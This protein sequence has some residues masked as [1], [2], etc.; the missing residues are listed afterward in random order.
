[1]QEINIIVTVKSLEEL[2]FQ[3]APIPKTSL[4][5]IKTFRSGKVLAA[6]NVK[7]ESCYKNL[8]VNFFWTH[9]PLM[10]EESPSVVKQEVLVTDEG[11]KIEEVVYEDQMNVEFIEEPDYFEEETIVSSQEIKNEE[12]VETSQDPEIMVE[13][14][15]QQMLRFRNVEGLYVPDSDLV[16]ELEM[17]GVCDFCGFTRKTLGFKPFLKHCATHLIKKMVGE[18][19]NCRACGQTFPSFDSVK[20]HA[21]CCI[22]RDSYRDQ[23]DEIGSE[24]ELFKSEKSKKLIKTPRNI[25]GKGIRPYICNECEKSFAGMVALQNH[26]ISKHFQQ[27]AKFKC[28]QCYCAFP[29]ASRLSAHI[30]TKHKIPETERLKC[31]HCKLT[32]ANK[33]TLRYHIINTHSDPSERLQYKCEEC[34]KVFYGKVTYKKHL[35]THLPTH[36]RPFRCEICEKTFLSKYRY[37]KHEMEHTN[38]EE[39]LRHCDICGKGF[40]YANS[41]KVHMRLHTGKKEKLLAFFMILLS[42]FFRRTTT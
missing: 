39:L 33:M 8:E 6:S 13:E 12:Y 30:V 24:E 28:D 42:N 41:L 34:D 2:F 20:I 26:L 25:P 10:N 37:Q 19:Y 5:S 7:C 23:W 4:E 31:P 36:E 14:P 17:S 21:L 11:L 35:L 18:T 16:K 9:A 40:K 38:P 29:D 15:K 1:M 27:L 32:L 22:A 3:V